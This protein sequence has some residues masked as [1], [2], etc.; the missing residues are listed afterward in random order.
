MN[1]RDTAL[2]A[3]LLVYSFANTQFTPDSSHRKKINFNIGWKF[4]LGTPSGSP[5]SAA[6]ND[7]SWADVCIPHTLKVSTRNC[8][9]SSDDY[10]QSATS[11]R[12]KQRPGE[13]RSAFL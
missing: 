13:H 7:A 6:F 2:L 9:N 12:C 8:D 1:M 3:V 4:Y 11:P 10:L 5:E